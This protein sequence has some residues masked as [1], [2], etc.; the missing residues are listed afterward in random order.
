MDLTGERNCNKSVKFVRPL[1][2]VERISKLL[3]TV[4]PAVNAEL[5]VLMALHFQEE[6][7]TVLAS[8]HARSNIAPVFPVHASV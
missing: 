4:P 7:E 2:A 1:Q 8:Q 5:T 3:P 6:V